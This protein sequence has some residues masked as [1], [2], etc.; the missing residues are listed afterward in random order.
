MVWWTLGRD[1]TPDPPLATNGAIDASSGQDAG[2]GVRATHGSINFGSECFDRCFNS[3]HSTVAHV[4]SL[5]LTDQ[6][7]EVREICS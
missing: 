2:Y 1:Q 6:G 5:Q 7:P 3:R 4:E